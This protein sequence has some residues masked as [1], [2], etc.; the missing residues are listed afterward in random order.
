MI[1]YRKQ[2]FETIVAYG[3]L[4]EQAIKTDGSVDSE[5][6]VISFVERSE[7]LEYRHRFNTLYDY[8]VAHMMLLGRN[9]STNVKVLTKGEYLT[10][11]THL[12]RYD[13]LHGEAQ[14]ILMK[15]INYSKK[16]DFEG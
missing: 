13:Q 8:E 14:E 16:E 2:Y 7:H 9:N 1:Y 11:V 4:D 5:E 6:Y 10:A 3:I 12:Q 15:M